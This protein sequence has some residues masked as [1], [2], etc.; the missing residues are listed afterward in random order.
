MLL[1]LA[2]QRA[3]AA[4][5]NAIHLYTH[6]KMLENRALYTR[7]GYQEYARRTEQGLPRVYMRKLLAD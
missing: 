2:E 1:R 7:I 3:L 4:G 6:E 5:F